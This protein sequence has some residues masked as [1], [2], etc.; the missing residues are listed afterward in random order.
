MMLSFR[1]QP[2]GLNLEP[3]NTDSREL[4]IALAHRFRLSVP[5][6]PE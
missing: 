5:L 6:R 4:R 2:A 1:G 3:V